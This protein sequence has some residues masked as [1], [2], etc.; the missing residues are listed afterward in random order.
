MTHIL[1]VMME[2]A[3]YVEMAREGVGVDVNVQ[4]AWRC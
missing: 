2:D 1:V 4:M 3:I